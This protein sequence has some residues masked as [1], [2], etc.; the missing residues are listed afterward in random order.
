MSK[1]KPKTPTLGV[2][3]RDVAKHSGVAPITVSRVI[4][5]AIYVRKEIRDRVQKSIAELNYVPNALGPSL[6]SNKTHILALILSDIT[7]PFWTTLSRGVEDACNAN[8]YYLMLCNT[9]EAQSKQDQYVSVM[10]QKQV[11]GFLLVPVKGSSDPIHKIQRQNIPLVVLDRTVTDADVDVVRCDSVE[12]AYQ[13]TKHLLQ[14][15]HQNIAILTGPAEISTAAD[16]VSGYCRAMTDAGLVINEDNIYWGNFSHE[17]GYAD[18][19]RLLQRMP[20]PT[21]LVAGNN[22]I[23]IGAMHVLSEANVSVP[24]DMALVSFDE[25]P[26]GLTIEPFFT[27]VVQ[28]AYQMGYK[29]AELLLSRISGNALYTCQEIILPIEVVIRRSSMQDWP[30]LNSL[31]A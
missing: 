21:A 25:F 11:D 29:A 3:I 13:I 22:F 24:Q 27:S 9:D 4:N 10:L 23:A 7:N 5:N 28:P 30:A 6:R 1:R 8:G 16:R 17:A 14:Q 20:R 19:R 18:T 15:G 2:N 12:G 31:R 26:L